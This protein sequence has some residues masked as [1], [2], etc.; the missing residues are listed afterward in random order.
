MKIKLTELEQLS[1]E[2]T[3]YVIGGQVHTD[4]KK[5]G[6]AKKAEGKR[7]K[8]GQKGRNRVSSNTTD[9]TKNDTFKI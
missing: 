9:T 8:S 3:F 2:E 7:K 6:K 4:K 5:K 1:K